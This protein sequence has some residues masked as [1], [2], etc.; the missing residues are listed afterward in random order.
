[1]LARVSVDDAPSREQAPLVVADWARGHADVAAVLGQAPERVRG[2]VGADLHVLAPAVQGVRDH[3]LAGGHG[4]GRRDVLGAAREQ[5]GA[6]QAGHELG[7]DGVGARRRLAWARARRPPGVAAARRRARTTRPARTCARTARGRVRVRPGRPA[8]ATRRGGGGARPDPRSA[9]RRRSARHDRDEQL[10]GHDRVPVARLACD[11][12]PR[13]APGRR[14]HRHERRRGHTCGL[15]RP[16]GRRRRGDHRPAGSR[17]RPASAPGGTRSVVFA[18]EHA[19][20]VALAAARHCSSRAGL[21]GAG[22]VEGT[23]S[24]QSQASPPPASRGSSPASARVQR[25]G[26]AGRACSA[27]APPP[28]TRAPPPGAPR[29]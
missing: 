6:N 25:R 3:R 10:I 2:A 15:R 7:A 17:L 4:P 1:M 28:R 29:T 26:P 14:G 12:R 9:A 16:C 11:G 5:V 24:G 22:D 13:L 23:G 21:A 27:V 8:P 20:A 19:L 18:A